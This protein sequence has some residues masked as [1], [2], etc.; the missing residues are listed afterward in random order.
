MVTWHPAAVLRNRSL[1]VDVIDDLR[2]FQESLGSNGIP[3]YVSYPC[4]KC[5]SHLEPHITDEGL[6]WCSK[7]WAWKQGKVGKGRAR[8]KLDGRLFS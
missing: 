3:P 7:H 1:I 2:T 8:K 4:V 6:S 5:G